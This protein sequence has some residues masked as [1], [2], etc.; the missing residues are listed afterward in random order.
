MT[1]KIRL[2]QD[3]HIEGYK[4]AEYR[5]TTD[6]GKPSACVIRD[7]WYEATATDKNDN[8]YLVVWRIKDDFN[9]NENPDESNACD[10][11]N[12]EE[13]INIDTGDNVTSRSK[14]EW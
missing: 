7:N 6:A 3:A 11:D 5:L 9:I 14:I 10:W 12:P 4:G 8:M 1:I 2:T 13:I